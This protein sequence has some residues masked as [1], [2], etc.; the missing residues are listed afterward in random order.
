MKHIIVMLGCLLLSLIV[1]AK[2]DYVIT[3]KVKGELNG[4][5][6]IYITDYTMKDSAEVKDGYYTI[7]YTFDKP[8]TL[9]VYTQFHS[10][11]GIFAFTPLVVDKPGTVNVDFDISKGY[12]G[13]ISN[14]ATA[15]EFN[16]F[17][18][19]YNKL[20]FGHKENDP[21]E[22]A[23]VQAQ[24]TDLMR[25]LVKERPD[26]FS[27]AY[28]VNE[29]TTR[30][31]SQVQ[32]ELYN[33]LGK[34]AKATEPG[35]H[36][37]G[38]LEG[39]KN[40]AIG[41]IVADFSLNAADGKSF[42]LRTLRGKYVI[43]DFWASWCGPC[44][45][46][47]P[48]LK[49]MYEKYK[50]NG[51]EVLSISV[52]EDKNNWRKA[53]EEERLPWTQLLDNKKVAERGFGVTGIPAMFLLGPDG[54]VLEKQVGYAP[55]GGL[56]DGKLE[57][58]F[59]SKT[60]KTDVSQYI[61]YDELQEQITPKVL[62]L[63]AAHRFTTLS[64]LNEVF[65]A[66]PDKEKIGERV[67]L[68]APANRELKG[69]EIFSTCRE[70]VMM[71]GKLYNCGSCDQLHSGTLATAVVLTADGICA[72][73]YHV[74]KNILGIA[75]HSKY[76]DSLLYVASPEGAV[77]GIEKILAIN[78]NGDVAIFKVNTGGQ[79]L[80]PIALGTPANVGEAV[81]AI[82]HPAGYPYYY[83]T[84]VV[85]RNVKI[86]GEGAP[87]IR[88]EIS[89]DFA[90]GSSGGPILDDKGNLIGMVASTSP[91]YYVQETEK[92]FQMVVKSTVPVQT[93]RELL[94]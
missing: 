45:A 16:G 61:D 68:P 15:V 65:T 3:G 9:Y 58:L 47:F 90:R 52:D 77:Y 54:K 10:E 30:L 92:A 39:L 44:R 5:N 56:I 17:M 43:I 51:L 34:N 21:L 62:Q 11:A 67:T 79:Q 6:R 57:A 91:I 59:E 25:Q 72:T 19:K 22:H 42:S 2:G 7:H 94:F 80:H 41:N 37:K 78:K 31:S 69:P 53:M 63:A 87:G 40:T 85:T 64:K 71:L 14:N 8:V 1:S 18:A 49:S 74:L 50:S 24:Q 86:S 60:T 89:A 27:T 73:N 23:N 76:S 66:L 70:G 83:S 75:Y 29:Y 38:R 20:A 35:L 26:R 93:I 33:G 13:T 4:R 28:I 12:T 81:H 84:G 46:S 55:E 88:M 36:L 82:T 32:Q 48:H